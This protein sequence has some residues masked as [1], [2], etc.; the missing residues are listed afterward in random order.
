MLRVASSIASDFIS[1]C[2]SGLLLHAS[3][4]FW[5]AL[6]A[7]GFLY[8][9]SEEALYCPSLFQTRLNVTRLQPCLDRSEKIASPYSSQKRTQSTK[10]QMGFAFKCQ[11][12]ESAERSNRFIHM[13]YPH[14]HR[15]NNNASITA[16]EHMM[17]WEEWCWWRGRFLFVSTIGIT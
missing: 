17:W 2:H 6:N 16:C 14:L 8:S 7:S 13:V 15:N 3:I 4:A 5:H 10:H 12:V 11:H 1:S 9:N